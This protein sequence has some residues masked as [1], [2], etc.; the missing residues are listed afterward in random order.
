MEASIY[1]LKQLL[2]WSDRI[3]SDE[4]ATIQ[5]V[6]DIL[7]AEDNLI[8]E[9]ETIIKYFI[10]SNGEIEYDEYAKVDGGIFTG[11]HEDFQE[12]IENRN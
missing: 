8:I 6:I 12:Y 3:G 5:E 4:I 2:K 9:E 11:K 7:K 1:I 10:N